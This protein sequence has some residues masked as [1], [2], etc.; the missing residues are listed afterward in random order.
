MPDNSRYRGLPRGRHPTPPLLTVPFHIYELGRSQKVRP[1]D[2]WPE[3][4]E[5]M[6]SGKPYFL[7]DGQKPNGVPLRGRP[8]LGALA[9]LT[10][11]ITEAQREFLTV[12]GYR[13]VKEGLGRT[14]R[15]AEERAY[16]WLRARLFESG[17]KARRRARNRTKSQAM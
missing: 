7:R 17:G 2:W 10:G 15:E 1:P 9:I 12:R 5:V 14:E 11:E 8:G 13:M 6:A 16:G 4:Q 3:A